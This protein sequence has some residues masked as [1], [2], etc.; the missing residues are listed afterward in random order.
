MLQLR[1][2]CSG[3][4]RRCSEGGSPQPAGTR[5]E[6][7][8]EGKSRCHNQGRIV[9]GNR[10]LLRCS[11]SVS[12]SPMI[13]VVG[14]ARPSDR[15]PSIFGMEIAFV[16]GRLEGQNVPEVVIAHA[17]PQFPTGL[18]P[19]SPRDPLPRLLRLPHSLIWGRCVLGGRNLYRSITPAVPFRL[20]SIR[21]PM[22][23]QTAT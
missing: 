5:D 21:G 19:L 16:A 4:G 22:G 2:D 3:G 11:S 20:F 13:G 10:D 1:R 12:G 9:H 6:A 14:R 18:S 23:D 17:C 7:P 15:K 8:W